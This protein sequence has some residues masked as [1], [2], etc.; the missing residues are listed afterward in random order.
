MTQNCIFCKIVAGEMP[1]TLLYQDEQVTAFRDIH[2][3][4]PTHILIIPN[5]HIAST[6]EA[7]P[8]DEALLG[9]L[10]GV[11]RLLAERE[12]IA[13][14]GYRLVINTGADGGQVV[15]HLHLHLLGGRKLVHP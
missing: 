6:N 14:N 3:V 1:T 5:R 13:A 12:N 11:A 8:E 15:F 4:A 2:P 10:I 7:A 9:H